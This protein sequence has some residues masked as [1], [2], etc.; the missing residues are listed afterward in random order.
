MTHSKYQEIMKNIGVPRLPPYQQLAENRWERVWSFVL[1]EDIPTSISMAQLSSE[2]G[3]DIRSL[4]LKD[5]AE[6][7]RWESLDESDFRVSIEVAGK[8]ELRVRTV[9]GRYGRSDPLS[10]IAPIWLLVRIEEKIGKIERIEGESKE[11]HLLWNRRKLFLGES[12]NDG[13]PGHCG[14][15]A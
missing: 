8:R 11:S 9:E 7:Y 10:V 6:K 13:Y 12:Y 5:Y 15:R 1:A 3:E 14:R 4:V 2:I